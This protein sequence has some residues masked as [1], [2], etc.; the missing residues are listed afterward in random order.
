MTTIVSTRVAALGGAVI[1]LLLSVGAGFTRQP[2][3]Q[4]EFPVAEL[5]T[6]THFH[7]LA[8]DRADP[9]RLY[10]ATHHGLYVVTAEGTATRV[11]DNTNDYMG[12]TPHP[13]D[14]TTLFASGHPA[15][16]GNMGV[17]LSR[18]GGVSWSALAAGSNGPVDFHQM[19]ISAADPQ[20]IYGAYAGG[21]QV[22]RDGGQSWEVYRPRLVGHRISA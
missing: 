19:T 7:G 16:G 1:I 12:F 14:P 9:S 21:L 2:H 13:T 22:S 18:N 6:H 17:L 8:V 3:A 11:S 20:V 10:L 4:E 5:S 15:G